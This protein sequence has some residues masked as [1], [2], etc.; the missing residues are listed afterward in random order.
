[1]TGKTS[2]KIDLLP[3]PPGKTLDEYSWAE[4]SRISASGLASE[5]FS[6]SDAKKVVLNGT[7]GICEFDNYETYAFIIGIDHNAELE[8]EHLIHFQLAKTAPSGGRRICFVD[9]EQSSTGSTAAFRMNLSN[10]NSGGWEASYM[11]NSICGTSKANTS[12]TFMGV[13]PT[14]LRSA[15]KS[16]TK[17]TNNTGANSPGAV[18]ATS[19]YFFILSPNEIGLGTR[20]GDPNED[21]FQQTYAYYSTLSNPVS[22]KHIDTNQ[23]TDFFFRSPFTYRDTTTMFMRKSANDVQVGGWPASSSSGIAPCFCV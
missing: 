23:P 6:V 15:L 11:R 13:I 3:P 19:D 22:Y 4:I 14:D 20:M 7:V 17:H 18:T 2:A 12:G 9:S 5:Y 21:S 10:T 8:G 16:V 1:M